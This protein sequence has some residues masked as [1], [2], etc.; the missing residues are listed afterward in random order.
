MVNLRIV[1]L[2]EKIL[3]NFKKA[4]DKIFNQRY[5]IDVERDTKS[6]NLLRV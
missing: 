6:R 1:M 3:K 5:N 2:I 4:I